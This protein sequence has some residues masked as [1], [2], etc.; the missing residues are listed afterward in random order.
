[1]NS[2]NSSLGDLLVKNAWALLLI[3]CKVALH[4]ESGVS[5]LSVLSIFLILATLTNLNAPA[6]R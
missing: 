5:R 4:S 1:M 2:Y 6:A 3:S